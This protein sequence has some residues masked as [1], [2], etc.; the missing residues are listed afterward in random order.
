MQTQETQ[1]TVTMPTKTTSYT[2][3]TAAD[4]VN[5]R[6]NPYNLRDL[7]K[8]KIQLNLEG[9]GFRLSDDVICT[10]QYRADADAL[11]DSIIT[12][13]GD[14]WRFEALTELVVTPKIKLEGDDKANYYF[15]DGNG[16][17]K[18]VMDLLDMVGE[19]NVSLSFRY[20]IK[21]DFPKDD[22][23]IKSALIAASI[24]GYNTAIP[25][26][27]EIQD[28]LYKVLD[29]FLAAGLAV[30]E[31]LTKVADIVKTNRNTM[32]HFR[33]VV[34]NKDILDKANA[35][36]HLNL[37]GQ[38]TFL[39]KIDEY[40]TKTGKTVDDAIDAF[41]LPN[42]CKGI[43]KERL[44]SPKHW[45]GM[46]NSVKAAE[47]PDPKPAVEPSQAAAVVNQGVEVNSTNDGTA[48]DSKVTVTANKPTKI[49]QPD[50]IEMVFS[51]L[52]ETISAAGEL[53]ADDS[54]LSNRM[55]PLAQQL[56]TF[57]FSLADADE[58]MTI[59]SYLQDVI[60]SKKDKL[61][62]DNNDAQNQL[63]AVEGYTKKVMQITHPPLDE[64]K[65]TP[66]ATEPTLN[67]LG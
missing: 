66:A 60:Q 6:H 3:S 42:Y 58:K 53:V 41:D 11:I 56:A 7:E 61:T 2:V 47:Y 24:S 10:E 54:N 25:V 45:D 67:P 59:L 46:Y 55:I 40:V 14:K 62:A 49:Y 30:E 8:V 27:N 39:S 31:A 65:P 18:I 9:T 52:T 64:K 35:F 34:L 43:G 32:S 51:D 36:K 5:F 12:R 20:T 15:L 38:A 48:V 19:D 21:S 23:G 13:D 22:D 44:T 17:F 33:R 1:E 57:A 50:D 29:M 16:R 63:K 28:Q 4:L 26:T 37:Q